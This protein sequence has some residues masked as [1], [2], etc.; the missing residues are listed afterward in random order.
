MNKKDITIKHF[1][2]LCK[3]NVQ[4]FLKTEPKLQVKNGNWVLLWDPYWTC[5]TKKS[6]GGDT[7]AKNIFLTH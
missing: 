7:N 1:L 3:Q 5:S 6:S 4:P 2:K